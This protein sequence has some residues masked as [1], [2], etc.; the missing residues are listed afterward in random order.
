MLLYRETLQVPLIVKLPGQHSRGQR[1]DTPVQLVDVAPT[2]LAMLEIETAGDFSGH[3][4]AKPLRGLE[5]PDLENRPIFAETF[6][7]RIEMGWSEMFSIIQGGHQY[8][9]SPRPELYDLTQ[10]PAQTR[11]L[12][13]SERGRGKALREALADYDL[14]YQPPGGVGEQ[15]DRALASLGYVGAHR[16]GESRS[17]TD[18]KTSIGIYESFQRG[19]L[20]YSR[21]DLRSAMEHLSRAI[22]EDTNLE[23]AWL[24]LGK[25]QGRLGHFDQAMS[26]FR[27]AA[28]L[29]DDPMQVAEEVADAYRRMNRG[30]DA[31]RFL[32]G[33][34]RKHPKKVGLHLMQARF[35][36]SQGDFESA[37]ENAQALL[38]LEPENAAA[39][40]LLGAVEA[41]LGHFEAATANLERAIELG[42]TRHG[43]SR[44]SALRGASPGT[45]CRS[46]TA[47]RARRISR[48]LRR[49][50]GHPPPTH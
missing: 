34:L 30:N 47:S 8:L 22:A 18:A 14:A 13:A 28:V 42:P 41:G 11:D 7:P 35:L 24:L 15:V 40:H 12:I 43:C 21:G 16:G 4:L 20:A 37:L 27:T 9:H 1:I 49:S 19:R 44:R 26:S 48:P 46:L 45:G 39:F 23:E 33:M 10:D 32:G 38:A 25:S 6:Y 17:R 2:V 29:S 5:D 31:V 50:A 3:S 36:M